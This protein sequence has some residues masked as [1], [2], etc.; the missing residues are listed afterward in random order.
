MLSHSVVSD[1]ATALEYC[2]PGSCVHRILQARIREWVAMPSSRGSSQSRDWIQVSHIACGFY[3]DWATREYW[4]TR[5][6]KDLLSY[7]LWCKSSRSKA[8]PFVLTMEHVPRLIR[9]NQTQQDPRKIFTQWGSIREVE[10]TIEKHQNQIKSSSK[11]QL[12]CLLSAC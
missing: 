6:M 2:L 7:Y 8:W 1:S 3:T 9:L 12:W 11:Y 5:A 4:G 10:W